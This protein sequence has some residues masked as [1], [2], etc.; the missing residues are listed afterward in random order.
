MYACT[1][2]HKIEKYQDIFLLS[3]LVY[4]SSYGTVLMTTPELIWM[5]LQKKVIKLSFKRKACQVYEVVAVG[6]Y[7]QSYLW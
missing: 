5:D 3:F 2:V 4:S 7:V 6:R 1:I